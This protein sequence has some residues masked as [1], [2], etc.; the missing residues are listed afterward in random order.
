MSNA[1]RGK[2]LLVGVAAGALALGS[3]PLLSG[4]AQASQTIS[5]DSN[6]PARANVIGPAIDIINSAATGT[7]DS[8]FLRIDV[9]PTT[10]GGTGAT[11]DNAALPAGVTAYTVNAST[12]AGNPVIGATDTAAGLVYVTSFA[13]TPA[14]DGV[15]I[16]LPDLSLAGNYQF[17]AW[18]RSTTTLA[19]TGAAGAVPG[20]GNPV[21]VGTFQVGGVPATTTLSASSA[22]VTSTQGALSPLVFALLKDS[23]G[24]PTALGPLEQLVVSQ[25]DGSAIT[26][27]NLNST[28]AGTGI[29][30]LTASGNNVTSS[31][32]LT[33]AGYNVR[34]N[35]G[36]SSAVTAG[37][38]TLV[39]SGG[40]NL[41]GLLPPVQFGL[42]VTGTGAAA[43]LAVTPGAAL[44]QTTTVASSVQKT[45]NAAIPVAPATNTAFT[46]T[47]TG[48]PGAGTTIYVSTGG[49]SALTLPGRVMINGQ[50]FLA[51]GASLPNLAGN[52]PVTAVANSSGVATFNVQ[53]YAPAAGNTIAFGV[54]TGVLTT[55]SAAITWVNSATAS[56]VITTAEGAPIA[57][58]S[59]LPLL[60]STNGTITVGTTVTN[61]LNQGLSNYLLRVGTQTTPVT[62][63]TTLTTIA[64]QGVTSAAGTATATIPAPAAGTTTATYKIV[65]TTADATTG[66]IASPLTAYLLSVTYTASGSPASINLT[67]GSSS[68]VP[69][70]TNTNVYPPSNS[71]TGTTPAVSSATA[72]AQTTGDYMTLVAALPSGV[73]DVITFTGSE[74]VLLASSV[75][76]G[77]NVNL[78]KTSL[79]VGT[80]G[81]LA[82]VYVLG[83]KTGVAT[84]T[85][86]AGTTT[87]SGKFTVTPA[88]AA[89]ARTI[90]LTAPTTMKSGDYV[91]GT[92]KVTDGYGNPVYASSLN[93]GVFSSAIG[94]TTSG[95]L[96]I[97][98]G[99]SFTTTTA[100][101]ETPILLFAPTGLQGA[102]TVT[103]A[104][105]VSLSQL[106]TAA[107]VAIA[108]DI[109][110]V[111]WPIA[112]PTA[113]TPVVVSGGAS[114]KTILIVG[115]RGT[116]SGKPG[117][118]VDGSTTGFDA[119]ATVKP[120]VRF[121]GQTEYTAGSARPAIKAAGD[122]TW[123]R[124]TGKKTYVYFTSDDDVVK[125]NRI[126]IAAN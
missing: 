16:A 89:G 121:P 85:A 120:W 116:V 111:G 1:M 81:S 105:P 4:P 77:F 7:D 44:Y 14:G 37:Q 70:E 109:P 15:T 11:S 23:A 106:T 97:Q 41:A 104:A 17:T 124:K 43:T 113:S 100:S 99:A 29:G 18:I 114:S 39:F 35:I 64:A 91:Q 54:A 9:A 2:R 24:R 28:S 71:P 73:N 34:A 92:V 78:G 123:Q 80:S 119:G 12:G 46:V 58:T 101:G 47:A 45:W 13:S 38:Y 21:V 95:P 117:I 83:T 20:L 51:S 53:V 110:I 118:I 60:I 36:G 59:T 6:T 26:N 72:S 67:S 125:S 31:L 27:V 10:A 42:T 62:S 122:F 52:L 48:V 3:I 33:A 32:L 96:S 90:T 84:V 103:V 68:L 98:S 69:S 126:I 57:A 79:S 107:G 93:G 66:A 115:E 30:Q 61:G 94:V 55:S 102:G 82:T 108:K 65:V 86:T 5:V 74:G 76:G 112:T 40:Q 22:T 8:L 25:A 19:P 88:K 87:S 50:Q 75:S 56:T 49:G 63:N